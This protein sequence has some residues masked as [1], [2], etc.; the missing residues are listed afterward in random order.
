MSKN[1]ECKKLINENAETIRGTHGGNDL[2]VICDGIVDE[3][4]FIAQEIKLLFLL[5]EVNGNMSS[6]GSIDYENE[7]RDFIDITR[8]RAEK[9]GDVPK[10]WKALC[11]WTYAIKYPDRSFAK[12]EKCGKNLLEVAI[13]NIKKTPGKGTTDDKELN[14]AVKG[15]GDVIRDEISIIAPDLVICGGTYEYAKKIYGQP[16][17]EKSDCG[18]KSFF[19]ESGT[20]KEIRFVEFVHP[21]ARVTLAATYA[22]A[23][24]L[25]N[26]FNLQTKAADISAK[27]I[28]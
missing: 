11:Y 12:A 16:N 28:H 6:G 7:G 27:K 20:G 15:Y 9:Q 5:K 4:T 19:I 14:A 3:K 22:Y 13:V 21:G 1:E 8:E 17:E 18:A 2:K 26:K 23:K 10:N 24:E 25:G